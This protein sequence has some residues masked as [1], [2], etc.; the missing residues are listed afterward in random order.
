[1]VVFLVSL[2][3]FLSIFWASLRVVQVSALASHLGNLVNFIGVHLWG[4]MVKN[5]RHPRSGQEHRQPPAHLYTP[6][7]PH[8]VVLQQ[9]PYRYREPRQY[10]GKV[11]VIAV[12]VLVTYTQY[13]LNSS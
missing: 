10:S 12:G 11:G 9:A 8:L 7:P 13:R 2:E 3:V 1:M 6:P 5:R 4:V